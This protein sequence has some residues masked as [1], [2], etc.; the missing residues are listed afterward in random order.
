MT[1]H[2]SLV[3]RAARALI[4]ALALAIGLGVGLAPVSAAPAA[5]EAITLSPSRAGTAHQHR[6]ASSGLSTPGIDC[7]GFAGREILADPTL[8]VVGYENNKEIGEKHAYQAVVVFDLSTLSAAPQGAALARATLG[9]SE[10]STTR[11]SPAGES[12]YGILPTCNTSLGVPTEAWDGSF[13]KLVPT[14]PA[15]VA[16]SSGATTGDSGGWDV[17]PQLKQWLA[18]SAPQGVLVLRGDDE[19]MDVKGMAMCLSY[20][21]DLGLTAEFTPR[22]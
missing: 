20:V 11:R 3:A 8:F 6:C 2:T 17:T 12:E 9:Y 21:F 18:S 1:P 4:P 5:Q 15:A 13:D 19:S 16:G 10:A 14:K 22:S 7:Q